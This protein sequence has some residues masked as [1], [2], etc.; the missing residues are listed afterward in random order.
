M[1]A[2]RLGRLPGVRQL[3]TALARVDPKVILFD[4]WHGTFADSPRAISEALHRLGA[5]YEHVWTIAP[6]NEAP[7]WG[8]SVAPH[9]REYL[10][11]LGR[12][13]YVV[14]NLGMPD[15]YRKKDASRYLQTWHGTPLK[16]IAFDIPDQFAGRSEYLR[17]LTRDVARWDGLVSPNPFSTEVLARAFRYDGPVLETGYPRND[18]LSDPRRDEI[19]A[20]VRQQLEIPDDARAVLYAPT[21]RDSSS[22][23]VELEVDAF[24]DE[25]EDH[26]VMLRLHHLVAAAADL[27]PNER[28]RDVSGHT[29]NRELMLAADVL[30]TDYSSM[31]FDFAVT[32]KPLL[33][34][35]YDLDR[36]RD[37]LRGFYFDFEAEAPGPL[38]TDT[39]ELIG[40]LGELE[41]VTARYGP[42]YDAFRARFCALEDG[43]ASERVIEAFFD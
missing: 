38:L 26:V 13:G 14:G 33:F 39:G 5:D 6:G 4:S 1:T 35:T 36:Y 21:W 11:Y 32:G 16:R 9:D 17:T 20:R 29:D 41:A 18:L 37:D 43:H 28:L 19:R 27:T 42:A 10:R 25:L 15:Y 40:A 23:D 12:A 31:M 22:F 8:T 3:P 7:E 34:L 30:V 2:L 24:L